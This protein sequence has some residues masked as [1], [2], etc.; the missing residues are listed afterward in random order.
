LTAAAVASAGGGGSSDD[1]RKSNKG[2]GGGTL[3]P[4]DDDGGGII[5]GADAIARYIFI[6]YA[7]NPI[8]ARRRVYNLWKHHQGRN[9]AAG[10]FKM[11]GALCLSTK[12][13]KRFHRL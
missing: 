3:A 7:A 4:D 11:N 9:E 8:R 2:T 5:Y 10:L 1:N 12:L 13:W 6:D